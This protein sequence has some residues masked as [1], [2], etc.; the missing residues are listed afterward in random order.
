MEKE[1]VVRNPKIEVNVPKRLR[2][3]PHGCSFPSDRL[4]DW[5]LGRVSRAANYIAFVLDN[6]VADERGDERVFILF[7]K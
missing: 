6:D 4:L 5:L 1:V 7:Y 2:Q 3:S